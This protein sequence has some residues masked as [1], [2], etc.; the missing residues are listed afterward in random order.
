MKLGFKNPDWH[1]WFAWRPVRLQSG[2]LVW[3]EW[4][5]RRPEAVT[6]CGSAVYYY[7]ASA[8]R[9]EGGA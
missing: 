3:L 2:E 8:A 7:R 6:G 1:S 4:V 5:E 9:T